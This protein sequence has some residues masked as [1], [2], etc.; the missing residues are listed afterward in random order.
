[1]DGINLHRCLGTL[2]NGIGQ[3]VGPEDCRSLEIVL[4]PMGPVRAAAA[5]RRS[6][7]QRVA[8]GLI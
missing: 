1:M 2:T 6:S 8:S 7:G 5:Q 4:L 3:M